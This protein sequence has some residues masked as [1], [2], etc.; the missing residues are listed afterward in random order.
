LP[1]ANKAFTDNQRIERTIQAMHY[2]EKRRRRVSGTCITLDILVVL[3][4]I[5]VLVLFFA[6]REGLGISI[7]VLAIWIG[8]LAVSQQ[9]L[10]TVENEV[11]KHRTLMID[12]YRVLR[13]HSTD[14]D[15]AMEMLMGEGYNL[16]DWIGQ[17][18]IRDINTYLNR[19]LNDR[20]A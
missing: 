15:K 16:D 3:T 2:L 10:R 20:G 5:C 11:G 14:H 18:Q 6:R 7:A 17:S 8:L 19:H 1:F 12:R 4:A 13:A 9:A